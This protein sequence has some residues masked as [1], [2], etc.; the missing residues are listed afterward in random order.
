MKALI[1]SPYLD[2][3]GG[4]ER[5]I[6][7]LSRIISDLGWHTY[8]AWDDLSVIHET[9]NKLS[10]N[11]GHV[12]LDPEIKKLY[13]SKLPAS[14]Y[15]KTRK[16]DLVFYLSDGS[17]PLLGGRRNFLHMQ[18]PFH[19][20]LGRTFSNQL[21]LR[22]VERII[23]NSRFTKKVIDLEYGVNSKVVYPPVEFVKPGKKENIIL[24]V[25]RFDHSINTKKHDL[26]IRAFQHLS[27]FLPSWK[28]VL[29]GASLDE[30]WIRELKRIS[31]KYP[32]K[33]LPNVSHPELVNLY[34]KAKIYWHAAG[35]GVDET[36]E[37]ENTEHFGISIVEALSANCVPLVVPKGGV[38]EIITLKE[39][40]WNELDELVKKTQLVSRNYPHFSEKTKAINLS[41]FSQ[42]RFSSELK[43][44]ILVQ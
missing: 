27:P 6:F 8:F 39:L 30:R 13:H 41:S 14:L 19:G 9:A 37:P 16:Y 4:G 34:R 1:V 25:G 12:G 28:L 22:N 44:L 18:V 24:S 40:W 7:T 3:V 5:Y 11:L 10:L 33:I 31:G 42:E 2:K 38:R 43:K 17:I 26:L 23:V 29:A 35:W 32:V 36:S 15:F 20:V 21:K